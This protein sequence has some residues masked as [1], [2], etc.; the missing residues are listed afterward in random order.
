MF[1]RSDQTARPNAEKL[2]RSLFTALGFFLIY[3]AVRMVISNA[4]TIFLLL[5][6][7]SPDKAV[8]VFNQNANAISLFC[9]IAVIVV[10]FIVLSVQ[11]RNITDILHLK[12]VRPSLIFLSFFSGIFLNLTTSGIISLLPDSILKNY[13]EAT[14]TIGNGPTTWFIISAVIVAPIV[15][16]LVF[17]SLIISSLLPG[18]GHIIS[19]LVSSLIFGAIHSGPVW[20]AYAFVLGSILACVFLRTGSVYS[21]IALHFGFN[22]M[23]LFPYLSLVIRSEKAV[24]TIYLTLT[25]LSLPLASVLIFLIFFITRDPTSNGHEDI[26]RI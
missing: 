21:S 25:Y 22:L 10:L 5:E 12:K 17:R 2:I 7:K 19:V 4:I 13:S 14:S 9:N 1:K 23:N 11:K 18:L 26:E 24:Q 8:S 3:Y 6:Y 20:I 15:E 16:E